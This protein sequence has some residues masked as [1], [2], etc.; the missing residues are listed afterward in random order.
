MPAIRHSSK[1]K[2][3]PEG[4]SDIEDDLLIFSN[5]MKDAQNTPTND[6]LE[7]SMSQWPKHKAQWPIFKISHQRSRYIHELYYEK[8]AISKELYDWLLK[9]GYA[10]AMLIAKWKKQGVDTSKTQHTAQ[11][12]TRPTRV[13]PRLAVLD[14]SAGHIDLLARWVDRV[15]RGGPSKSVVV[16]ASPASY[17]HAYTT[18]SWKAG[19]DTHL[20]LRHRRLPHGVLASHEGRLVVGGGVDEELVVGVEADVV[21]A[22]GGGK[23]GDGDVAVQVLAEGQAR[24]EVEVGALEDPDERARLEVGAARGDVEGEGVVVDRGA[25][26]PGQAEL[27]DGGAGVAG[28][29]ELAVDVLVVALELQREGGRGVVFLGRHG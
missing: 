13:R 15:P 25:V 24:A 9:N 16:V 18:R 11:H 3:P 19:G 5:K 23:R 29:Q 2:P 4:F 26:R 28:A 12:T 8:G 27:L 22:G 7:H 6:I 20:V 17:T 21:V 1:R 10:D 14:K